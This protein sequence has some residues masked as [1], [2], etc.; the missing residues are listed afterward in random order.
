MLLWGV[1]YATQDTLFKALVAS[2]LPEGKRN[3]AFGLFYA[4]YGVGWLFGSV[5]AGVLYDRW[6]LGLIIFSVAAQLSS[7]PVFVLAGRGSRPEERRS[8]DGQG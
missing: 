4:G 7:V 2:T 8:S 6:R 5:T 1:G 3:L